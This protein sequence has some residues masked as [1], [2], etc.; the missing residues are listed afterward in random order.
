LLLLLSTGVELGQ[1]PKFPI[2]PPLPHWSRWK[3]CSVVLPLTGGRFVP[4]RS[5]S[6]TP[7]PVFAPKPTASSLFTD[8]ILVTSAVLKTATLGVAFQILRQR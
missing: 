3:L 4:S 2:A 7:P 1:I 5:R 8:E 6:Q